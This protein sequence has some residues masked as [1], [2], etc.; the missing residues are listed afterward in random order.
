MNQLVEF[1]L[2]RVTS[3]NDYARTLMDDHAFVLVTALFQTAGRGRNGRQWVGDHGAN[4][5]ASFG[6]QHQHVPTLEDVSAFMARGAL[7]V[8]NAI[9]GVLR[10]RTIRL[11]YPNDVQVRTDGGWAKI[12]GILVEH[13]FHGARCA[14]TIVG[15]GVNVEQVEFPETITQ[16]CTSLRKLG[17]DVS[18]HQILT[19]IRDSFVRYCDMPWQDVHQEWVDA[20][21]LNAVRVMLSDSASPH[22]PMRV[23]H[24]GRLVLRNEDTHHERIISDG[25]TLRYLD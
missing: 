24:D 17:I 8:R 4:I 18:T 14:S 9:M 15:I 25:D 22:T 2:P 6:M 10:D 23:M 5:Y 13:E 7:S 21:Q 3:T 19:A 1:H 20:L 16:P 11:K 12:A